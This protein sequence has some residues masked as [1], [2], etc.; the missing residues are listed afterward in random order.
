[1]PFTLRGASL[2]QALTAW[3]TRTPAAAASNAVT[4]LVRPV[5]PEVPLYKK[6]LFWAALLG[7]GYVG[8]RVVRKSKGGKSPLAVG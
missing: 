7:I 5:A 1:M 6:P 8:Y 4:T 3:G 2:D